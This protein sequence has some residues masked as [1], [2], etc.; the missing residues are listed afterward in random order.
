MGLQRV[1]C[2]SPEGGGVV[3]KFVVGQRVFHRWDDTPA[4]ITTVL[5]YVTLE[6]GVGNWEDKMIPCGE[7]FYRLPGWDEE[8]KLKATRESFYYLTDGATDRDYRIEE[9]D[10]LPQ[11]REFEVIHETLTHRWVRRGDRHYVEG[12]SS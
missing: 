8:S 6:H 2:E 3:N 1:G 7:G 5:K 11:V 9:D 4:V 12:V 10:L